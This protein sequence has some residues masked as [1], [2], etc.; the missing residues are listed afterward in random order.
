MTGEFG[1]N[2]TANGT[3]RGKLDFYSA[4]GLYNLYF[5]RVVGRRRHRALSYE[6]EEEDGMVERAKSG[7]GELLSSSIAVSGCIPGKEK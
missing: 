2:Y 4:D 7:N 5:E 3:Y 6:E 1:G